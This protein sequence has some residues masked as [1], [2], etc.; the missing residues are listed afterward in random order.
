MIGFVKFL[1]CIPYGPITFKGRS[2]KKYN[3][4]EA[5]KF[6]ELY[7]KTPLFSINDVDPA[8]DFLY[9]I[10]YK[11]AEKLCT[12]KTICV[13][14]NR[15]PW[16]TNEILEAVSDMDGSDRLLLKPTHQQTLTY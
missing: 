1:G 12:L 13:T 4:E 7:D 15:P 16:I 14:S 11:C 9:K 3:R 10:V 2:Y 6:Y 5:I 8:W